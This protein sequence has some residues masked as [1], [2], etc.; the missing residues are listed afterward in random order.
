MELLDRLIS[1]QVQALPI[2]DG[3]FI[4]YVDASDL[5]IGAVLSQLQ[6]GKERMIAYF[7]QRHAATEMN[8]Y[9]TR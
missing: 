8:Y 6:D 5:S 2:D 7:S 1:A 3:M 4:L 9:I